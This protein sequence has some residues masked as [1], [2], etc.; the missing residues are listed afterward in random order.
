MIAYNPRKQVFQGRDDGD[1]LSLP[2][3]KGA[4]GD[5]W[6]SSDTYP[7]WTRINA[8]SILATIQLVSVYRGYTDYTVSQEDMDRPE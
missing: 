6:S 3:F 2:R 5:G 8:D 1:G 7:E 4:D